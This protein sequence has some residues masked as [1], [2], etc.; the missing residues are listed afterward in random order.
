MSTVTETKSLVGSFTVEAFAAHLASLGASPTWW[1]ERKRAAY[2]KFAAL[3]LPKR[4]DETWR[5]SNISTLTLDGFQ[6]GRRA[7]AARPENS[8]FGPPALAFVN[9]TLVS[10]S[11]LVTELS[12]KGVII[13]TLSD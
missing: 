8:P 9:N 10:H 1:L 5:F 4:T 6:V 3:P 11:P 13:T 12:G 2:E 7:G